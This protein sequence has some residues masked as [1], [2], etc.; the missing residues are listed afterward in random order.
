[1][2]EAI[3]VAVK[4]SVPPALAAEVATMTTEAE[5]ETKAFPQAVHTT[6]SSAAAATVEVG[7][8]V[9]IAVAVAASLQSR[10]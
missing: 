1:M 4:A 3:N 2:T 5:G 9:E 8:R 7:V 10:S 6:N